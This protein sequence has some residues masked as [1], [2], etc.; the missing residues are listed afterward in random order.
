MHEL[1]VFENEAFGDVRVLDR[2]GEPWF[3]AK[4]V[5]SCLELGNVGQALSYLDDDEK[6]SI[7]PNIITA[8]VGFDAMMKD[9]HTPM[10]SVIPEAG[11]GGRPLSLVSEPG[12]YSLIL[13]SRKPEAKAFK[14]WVTHDVI[15]SIRKR[16]LYATPHTVEAMLADP[17]TA[18]KLLTSLK[19]ER[20]KSAALAAKVEQDAPKVLFADSVAASRSSILVG[21]LAKLLVQNGVKIGQNR[22]FVY[23]REKGFL[24]QSGS[25]K[26]TPTQRSMEMGLFEVKEYLV[27]NPDGSTRTRFTTRVTGKGQLYFVKKFLSATT[28]AAA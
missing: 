1:T 17:D 22:L 25:R 11:R 13:R 20:A 16:G 5:C 10:R 28:P 9:A 23:L 18:I 14:R 2:N 19:E 7:D 6:S 24:I 12:L 26:N 3:V 21:D 4:D 15:P 27:H 8:D